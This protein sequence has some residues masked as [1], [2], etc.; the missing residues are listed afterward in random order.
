MNENNSFLQRY[1]DTVGQQSPTTSPLSVKSPSRT[2]LNPSPLKGAKF[3]VNASFGKEN[4]TL[5]SPVNVKKTVTTSL[6]NPALVS[7]SDYSPE[8]RKYYEFLCRVSEVKRWM[9]SVIQ[10]T[11]PSEVE[12]A[13]GDVMRDGVFLAKVTNVINP[14]LAPSIFPAGDKLQFKHTQNINA[15]FS[16]VEH[17]GVPDSFRFELQDLY[18]KKDLPHVF[19]T[20]HILISIINKKWP[21]KTAEI[22]NLSG[23]IGF[24]KQDIKTCK[25]VWPRIKDFTTLGGSANAISSPMKKQ[26]PNKEGLI[27]DFSSPTRSRDNV[28]ATTA[29]IKTPKDEEL[30]EKTPSKSYVDS[31]VNLQEP[32]T[33]INNNKTRLPTFNN[34][35]RTS[36]LTET[37]EL[38]YSPLKSM[39]F[40]YYSPSISKYLTFDTD[41]YLRRSQYRDNELGHYSTFKYSPSRYSPTR[42]E[43]MTEEEFLD[44][45]EKIQGITKGVNVRYSLYLQNQLLNLFDNDVIRLQSNIR[46][47]TIRAKNGT[48]SKKWKDIESKVDFVSITAL[49][50]GFNTRNRIDKFR[51]QISRQEHNIIPL[52]KICKGSVVRKRTE[53]LSTSIE[54]NV[55]YMIAYQ[56][57]LRGVLTRQKYSLKKSSVSEQLDILISI[58]GL[59][60]A[61]VIRKKVN[62]LKNDL[63]EKGLK[64]IIT[65]QAYTKANLVK[66]K[67]EKFERCIRKEISINSACRGHLIRNRIGSVNLRISRE[68]DN[69]TILQSTIRGLLVRYTLDLVDEIIEYS[70]VEQLQSHIRGAVVRRKLTESNSHYKNNLAKIVKIQSLVRMHLLRTAYNELMLY[71]NPSLWAVKKF[72]WLLNNKSSIEEFQDKVESYQASLDSENMK[73][74]IL[75]KEIRSQFDLLSVLEKH[76]LARSE[77]SSLSKIKS[78][79]PNSRFPGFEGLFYL[80]QVEPSYWKLMASK[81]QEFTVR[82]VYSTFTT[83]NKKMGNRER[84]LYAKLISELLQQDIQQVSGIDEYL[85]PRTPVW[86]KLLDEF[87]DKECGEAFALF[88]PLL[89]FIGNK[90]NQF[91]SDPYIIYER[92]YHKVP[93]S[94]IQP[95]EDGKVKEMFIGNLRNIWHAVEMVAE[96]FSRKTSE[97]P[98]ELR[99]LGTKILCFFSDRNVDESRSL[100]AVAELLIHNFV[101]HFLTNFSNFG[102]EQ[103]TD[104]SMQSKIEILLESLKI[105]FYQKEFNGY[106]QPL[107]QYCEEI[108]PHIRNLMYN[109]LVDVNYEQEGYAAIYNDMI[110]TSPVLELLAS[111]VTEISEKF[112][113]FVDDFTDTDPI[114]D[115]LNSLDFRMMTRN[116]GRI[117]LELDSSSYRFLVGDDRLRRV[118]DQVKRAFIFMIQVEDVDTNLYDLSISSVIPEDEPTFS[119]L[120]DN[121]PKMKNDLLIKKLDP[122]SYFSLKNVTLRNIHELTN[123]NIICVKDSKLQ[124]F[125]N[126]IANTIKNPDYALQ[127][128]QNEVEMTAN[129]LKELD[130]VNKKLT[131]DLKTMKSTVSSIIIDLQR[132]TDFTPHHKGAFGNL[133][134]AYKKVQNKDGKEL[135]GLKYKWT[136]RQLYEKG[137]LKSIKGENMGKHSVKVFGS[138]GPKFPDI[139]FKISTTDGSRFGIQLSD[140]RKGPEHKHPDMTDYFEFKKLLQKQVDNSKDKLIVLNNKVELDSGELLNLVARAFYYRQSNY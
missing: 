38:A 64:D 54:A 69:V 41:F 34:Y 42:K 25:R 8:E 30:V 44:C 126:D 16:L 93:P 15:F 74:S 102:F 103:Y 29:P 14:S 104:N 91:E 51:I 70:N 32:K 135:Q 57:H 82:N 120:L 109:L 90:E 106:L 10:E 113:E 97:I 40:S 65:L 58:Q 83:T 94:N 59:S 39:S 53:V 130:M 66:R 19:E 110:S 116:S 62:S 128:I 46:A 136:A 63:I 114:R 127:F 111:K 47:N 138:S 24:D 85:A 123:A 1:M 101:S 28:K 131:N 60:R 139:V 98:V 52:Q 77:D 125:L 55:K 119:A 33:P 20:L 87:I 3:N 132:S 133:K 2:N 80:L 26:S 73:K 117:T 22:Q 107:N 95:I 23:S 78:K 67:Y 36:K 89:K 79:I 31:R 35:A 112:L 9:E 4:M 75:L 72:V 121:N 12:L 124:N 18:N 105:V 49:C 99:F 56:G 129:T 7:L 115:V 118:Y 96:I 5:E 21:G 140:K 134:S 11:L 27:N 76:N 88:I 137:V 43:R 48:K 100:K 92:I 86:K 71:P 122:K 108:N 17:V 13:T 61:M 84:K 45:V 50:R 68:V 6:K 81:E 37:P